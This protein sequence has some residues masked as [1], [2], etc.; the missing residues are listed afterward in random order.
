MLLASRPNL[1][2]LVL[3]SLTLTVIGK[4]QS[5]ISIPEM[6]PWCLKRVFVHICPHFIP[7]S[8]IQQ[9]TPFVPYQWNRDSSWKDIFQPGIAFQTAWAVFTNPLLMLKQ[10][11]INTSSYLLNLHIVSGHIQNVQFCSGY[12]YRSSNLDLF[13]PR[14]LTFIFPPA[15]TL[16]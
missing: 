16:M 11:C 4:E 7:L 8:F 12:F 1:S 3:H 14:S 5:C 2:P 9:K 10:V 13:A 6:P 15:H